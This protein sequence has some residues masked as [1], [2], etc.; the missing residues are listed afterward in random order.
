MV[1]AAMTYPAQARL[2]PLVIGVPAT[3]L[4]AYQVGREIAALGTE[5]RAAAESDVADVRRGSLWILLYIGIV[6]GGGFTWGGPIAV[7]TSQRFW[8]K[9]SWRSSILSGVVAFVL[10]HVVLQEQLGIVLF[11]GWIDRW[12]R[13]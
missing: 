3:T 2:V 11:E 8:L 1:V 10:I 5:P 12:V 4:A 9:E 13:G 7:A 6:L